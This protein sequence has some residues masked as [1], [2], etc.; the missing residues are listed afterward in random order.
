MEIA[1]T[2]L[3]SFSK[4][5]FPDQIFSVYVP[6]SNILSQEGRQAILNSLKDVK[7]IS[8]VYHPSDNDVNYVQSHFLHPYDALDVDRGAALG[9][10][11]L[12]ESFSNYLDWIYSSAPNIRDV[13]GSQMGRAVEQY[14]K[15]SVK[16]TY[17][18]QGME[19]SLGGFYKEAYLMLRINEGEI[20]TIVGGEYENITGNLYLIYALKD[21]IS[22]TWK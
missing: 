8:S 11:K 4:N 13:T 3:L 22:I 9:W 17:R 7:T 15:L 19:I 6:P 20:N 1:L 10:E 16:K 14:D 2:E 21:S 12:K 18:N 5:L